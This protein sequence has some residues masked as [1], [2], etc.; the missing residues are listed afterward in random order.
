MQDAEYAEKYCD[1]ADK[2]DVLGKLKQAA[3]ARF[4]DDACGLFVS[5]GYAKRSAAEDGLAAIDVGGEAYLT[6]SVT[7][8]IS[9]MGMGNGDDWFTGADAGVRL[10]TPTRLAAFVGAGVFAGYA[11]ETIPA[12]DDWKDNDDDGLVDERGEDDERISGTLA[13]VYP[14]LGAHFW[15]TPK[16]RLT[17]YGRYM[18][19]TEGSSASDWQFGVGLAIFTNPGGE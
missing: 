14:E 1:G 2:S 13:T 12:D 5:G 4:Q 16:V 10:Q 3:D 7:G 8:R 15:W 9:W 18:V 11:E 6:S 19:T 17:S